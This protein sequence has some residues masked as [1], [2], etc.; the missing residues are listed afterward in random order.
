M[1][2][3]EQLLKDG[4]CRFESVLSQ[5]LLGRLIETTDRMLA[6]QTDAQRQGKRAQGSMLWTSADPIFAELIALPRALEAFASMGWPRPTFTD[7]YIISKPPNSPRLFWHY[8]WFAWEDDYSFGNDPPQL[9]AMYYLQGTRRENGCLRV[10][11][12]SHVKH[13]A[14]HDALLEPHGKALSEARDMTSPAFSDRP[15]EIDVRVKA[16]DLL[17]GDARLLHAAH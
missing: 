17:I 11:P 12:G 10:I 6:A 16:G 13:N 8:D 3:R 15:D 14:L 9:F 2:Y 5:P 7:G 4:F 1:T